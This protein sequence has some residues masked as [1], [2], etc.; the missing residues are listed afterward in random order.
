MFSLKYFVLSDLK[1]KQW[2]DAM[3]DLQ[4]VLKLEPDNVKGKQIFNCSVS[5]Q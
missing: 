3:K 4:I 5:Q 2:Q 1:C